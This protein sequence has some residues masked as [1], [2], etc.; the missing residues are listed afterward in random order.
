MLL[1]RIAALRQRLEQV[2]PVPD[3]ESPAV[4]P[5]DDEAARIRLLETR[6][7]AGRRQGALLDS[8]F[9]QIGEQAVAA[10]PGLQLPQHL[11]A[12]ARRLLVAGQGWLQKVRELADSFPADHNPLPQSLR[13]LGKWT[14]LPA[15]HPLSVHY[16]ETVTM[17]DTALR[18]VQAY[19][20]SPSAQL[21]LCDGLEAILNVVGQR[22]GMLRVAVEERRTTAMRIDLVADLLARAAAGQSVELQSLVN[23]AEA[24]VADVEQGLPLQFLHVE[25]LHDLRGEA[26]PIWHARAVACHCLTVAQVMARLIRHEPEL[27]NML[28]E[29]VLAALVHDVGMLGVPVEVYAHPGPLDEEQR[30][31]LESHTRLGAEVAL[32]LWPAAAWM[33]EATLSHHER[34]DGTGYPAGLRELQLTPLVRF[35]A[36][37]D[38]YA[39]LCTPRP[40]RP[41]REPRTAL[42]DTLLLADKGALDRSHAERLLQLSFYPVGTLVEMADG[43]IGLVAASAAARRDLTTPSR[44]VVALLTDTHG[45][46]LP[47][48][49][50]LNL[51]EC[52]GRTIVRGLPA[53]ERRRLLARHYP[54]LA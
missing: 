50:H 24:V 10:T 53:D 2:A 44:P 48:P 20:E 34:H 1:N 37:C 15:D 26:A 21:R 35:L 47:T 45:R 38:V 32:R 30:R 13:P 18:T 49:R 27:R 29:P 52:E 23:V 11:T 25:P 43:A 4:M 9:R 8:S 3:A 36:V 19:P 33:A 28:I 14:G 41:A 31:I 6:V 22:V 40:H 54:E 39:A 12:R 46:W 17:L 51:A 7:V 16:C 42:T 5:A